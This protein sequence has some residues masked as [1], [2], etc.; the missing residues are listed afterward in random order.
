V[1]IYSQKLQGLE[2]VSKASVA[3]NA[4]QS[5]LTAL[6]LPSECSMTITSGLEKAAPPN[7]QFS[8]PL[9]LTLAML[10][11]LMT[12]HFECALN[13]VTYTVARI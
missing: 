9:I 13:L 3:F 5:S 7:L 2:Y 10:V 12:V 4:N 6:W 11:V 1:I 8:P